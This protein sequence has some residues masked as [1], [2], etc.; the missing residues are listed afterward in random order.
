MMRITRLIFGL[1]VAVG[2][3]ANLCSA[4]TALNFETYRDRVEP[5]GGGEC[6][7]RAHAGTPALAQRRAGRRRIHGV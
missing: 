6:L 1:C 4:Q 5:I 3:S 7:P 2:G